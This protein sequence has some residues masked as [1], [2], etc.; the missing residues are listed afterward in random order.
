[1]EIERKPYATPHLDRLGS[2]QELTAVNGRP[3]ECSALPGD[4]ST[5]DFLCDPV[6]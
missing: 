2:V 3:T 1:M 6:P 4:Q 5:E